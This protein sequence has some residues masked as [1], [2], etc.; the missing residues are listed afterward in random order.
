M[1]SQ[2][3]Q[4][5][6]ILSRIKEHQYGVPPEECLRCGEPHDFVEEFNLTHATAGDRL[7]GDGD[8]LVGGICFKCMD[9]LLDEWGYP[10]VVIDD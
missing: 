9:A 1:G 7:A 6:A 3:K 8:Q 2:R 4:A 5:K 10:E